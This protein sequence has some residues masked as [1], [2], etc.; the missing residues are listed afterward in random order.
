MIIGIPK[1]IKQDEARV[2]IT[3][4]GVR[5]ACIHG[6]SVLVEQTAGEGSG[7]TDAEYK[8]AGAS[9][10]SS[11]EQV[12]KNS[13]M[14]VKVK[15]PLQSEFACLRRDLVLFT[16]LHLAAAKDL[17]ENLMKSRVSA[18]AYETIELKD[19]SLPLLIPMSEVAGRLSVQVGAWALEAGHGGRGVLVSGV[20]GVAPANVLILGAGTAGRNA[21]H[22]AMGLGANVVVIDINPNKLRYLDDIHHGQLTTLVAN[23]ANIETELAKADLVVGAVLIAGAKAPKLI[24]K[25]YLRNMKPG[26]V[27]V[28]VAIDQGGISE[29]S[30]PTTHADPIY[31][32]DSVVH[33]CVANMPGAVPRTSTAALTA[34]TLPHLLEIADKGPLEAARTNPALAKGFNT[35]EGAI[36]HPEVAA[37]FGLPAAELP[38]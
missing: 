1:E 12:W 3:S 23:E 7:I 5:A 38:I 29:T 32:V 35:Y 8:Q 22:I 19:K 15:E 33:Y 21:T 27:I 24:K 36:T 34:A 9:I 28:D 11:A 13:E 14:V 6:H 2:A 18:I 16:Y 30:K 10:I 25:E 31:T 17:T 26:S 4:E 20:S 37:A